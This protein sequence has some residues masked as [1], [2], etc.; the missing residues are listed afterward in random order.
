MWGRRDLRSGQDLF[1]TC[2][3][4]HRVLRK[5]TFQ[6]LDTLYRFIPYRSGTL[7]DQLVSLET[8][9]ENFG[10]LNA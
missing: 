6:D 2:K 5:L 7:F 4:K 3:R 10:I 8:D 1:R 9:I